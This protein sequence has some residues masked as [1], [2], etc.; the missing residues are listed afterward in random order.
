MPPEIRNMISDVNL[1][2]SQMKEN[3]GNVMVTERAG[4]IQQ[5]GWKTKMIQWLVYVKLITLDVSIKLSSIHVY[6]EKIYDSN[7][8]IPVRRTKLN[9]DIKLPMQNR[10]LQ[11]YY[12]E[13][14]FGRVSGLD[15]Q[16]KKNICLRYLRIITL[17]VHWIVNQTLI[18]FCR[19]FYK[20]K[21]SI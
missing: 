17:I 7:I 20:L 18:L 8:R 13:K 10:I 3:H 19:K 11:S 5:N 16:M 12:G 9:T 4:R 1:C 15:G 6:I 2:P 21:S 14:C